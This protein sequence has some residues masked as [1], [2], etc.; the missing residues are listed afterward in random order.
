MAAEVLPAVIGMPS[1]TAM[2]VKN[3]DKPMETLQADLDNEAETM[4]NYRER[5]KECEALGEFAL[6]ETFARS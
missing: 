3:T 6:C 1:V 4:R 2:P 5:V